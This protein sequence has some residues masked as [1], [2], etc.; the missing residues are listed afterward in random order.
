[1]DAE[2]G[3]MCVTLQCCTQSPL[4]FSENLWS[5]LEALFWVDFHI[6]KD[7]E[8][9][10]T[11]I[12][13]N[14]FCIHYWNGQSTNHSPIL[15]T[16]VHIMSSKGL[17]KLKSSHST[18]IFNLII[19]IIIPTIPQEW[20][21]NKTFPVLSRRSTRDCTEKK[22]KT[23]KQKFNVSLKKYIFPALNQTFKNKTT[24]TVNN[25]TWAHLD[26]NLCLWQRFPSNWQ[27]QHLYV[28]PMILFS[29]L[30]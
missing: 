24:N 26:P 25:G 20:K 7:L 1:M 12:Y 30:K 18:Y 9:P 3:S 14:C 2:A 28:S 5:D 19:A 27:L 23:S 10:V 8:S 16:S 4:K 22:E 29:F 21:Y 6:L 17:T 13:I 11:S 15:Y